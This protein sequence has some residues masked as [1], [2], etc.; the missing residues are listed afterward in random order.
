M[1]FSR[2]DD[3]GDG[4]FEVVK[5]VEWVAWVEPEVSVMSRSQ[6]VLQEAVWMLLP[7]FGV[8][9]LDV[10]YTITKTVEF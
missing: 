9:T 6:A 4:Q 8:F 3:T 7:T 1:N 2:G 10:L 5:D